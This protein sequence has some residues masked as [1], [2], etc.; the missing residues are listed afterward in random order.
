MKKFTILLAILFQIQLTHAQLVTFSPKEFFQ[1]IKNSIIQKK[2]LIVQTKTYTNAVK[3][4]ERAKRTQESVNHLLKLEQRIR[5][6][7]KKLKGLKGLKWNNISAIFSYNHHLKDWGEYVLSSSSHTKDLQKHQIPLYNTQSI[8]T[9][10][11]QGVAAGNA[12]KLKEHLFPDEASK[13][14]E[15]RSEQIQ[16]SIKLSQLDNI[17]KSQKLHLAI[18]YKNLADSLVDKATE[19]NIQLLREDTKALSLTEGER[20]S[21]QSEVQKMLL[22]SIELREKSIL[23]LEQAKHMEPTIHQQIRTQ[24]FFREDI[25]QN[26]AEILH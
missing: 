22:R 1:S 16:A 19:M 6:E 4:Y 8:I 13:L 26:F 15:Y 21:S 18:I 23:N 24:R 14:E 11:E 25:F 2:Q 3:I 20:I 12:N 10:F 17:I 5:N 9:L 7:L